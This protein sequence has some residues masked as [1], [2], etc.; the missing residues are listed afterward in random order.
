[1][2]ATKQ[3]VFRRFWYPVMPKAHLA[4]GK[5][6]PFRLM[7]WDIVL[8]Q[9]KDGPAA[10][11]DQCPHRGAKLSLGFLDHE[12]PD[13]PA[14]ACPYHGWA[15]GADG[16]CRKVPQAHEPLRG[17]KGGAKRHHAAER[18]GWI[19]VAL[20]DPIAPIPDIPE[21]ALPGFRQ[22]DEFHE[23]W[24]VPGLRLME[25]SFDMAH[26]SYVHAESFGI[27]AEPRPAPVE[28]EHKPWGFVMR[29]EA[30][31]TNKGVSKELLKTDAERTLRVIEGRWF[32]PFMRAS[33]IDYPTGLTHV[34]VTAATPI[35]D[36][37]SMIC[38]WVY[39]NDTEADAPAEKVIAFDRQVTNEDRL[40]LE[41]SSWDVP[42]S[43]SEELH[44]PSDK[45]GIEMRRRLAALLA[46]HGEEEARLPR[47]E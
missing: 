16:R 7:G 1:M 25:N 14:L 27:L 26:L 40:I 38:Q 34:L 10:I 20:E 19:W 22:I 21:A 41:S 42:L 36:R 12:V 9:A 29:G 6:V 33:R 17:M 44:M 43:M 47:E 8:W 5:P 11:A 24:A 46:E 2:L 23:E 15:F 35:D 3:K 32:L 13:G 28:I 31:V 4:G 39:R 30:P 37:R 45:P 18:Y